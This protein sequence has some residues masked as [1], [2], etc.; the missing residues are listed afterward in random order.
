[1]T[2]AK[3]EVD[4]EYVK[5]VGEIDVLTSQVLHR[6]LDVTREVSRTCAR[7]KA[8]RVGRQPP[9][10]RALPTDVVHRQR[11]RDAGHSVERVTKGLLRCQVCR[12]NFR[13]L[14]AAWLISG[15]VVARGGRLC[16]TAQMWSWP[17]PATPGST[18]AIN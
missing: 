9:R 13:P 16:V 18:A 7:N 10:P 17:T 14:W 3:G 2:A 5:L 4:S 8:D 15:L 12:R 6:L 1:M 11:M